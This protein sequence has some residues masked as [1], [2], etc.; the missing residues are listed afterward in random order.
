M[1]RALTAVSLALV[2]AL[3]G[4]GLWWSLRREP[5]GTILDDDQSA[6]KVA[7]A[8]PGQLISFQDAQIPL[9]SF[10]WLPPLPGGFLAAQVLSQ[11]DR[12]R[13]ALFQG[14]APR[15]LLLVQKPVGVADGF[16]RFAQLKDAAQAPGGL[17]VLLY[18]A[19]DSA[20]AEPAL[21]LAL[22]E[23]SQRVHWF[24]RGPCARVAVSPGQQPAVFLFG[25]KASIQRLDLNATG[26]AGR[27]AAKSIELPPEMAEVEDLL[28]TGAWSFLVSHRNGL[29][30]WQNKSGWTLCPAPEDRGVDCQDWK[31][32]LT[33]SG[34]D[35]WWQAVPG[36]LVKV[37]ADGSSLD[38]WQADLGTDPF[39]RDARLLRLL[40]TDPG[41]AL[42][43]TLAS[44]KPAPPAPA[45]AQ[46][47]LPPAPEAPFE[48]SGQEAAVAPQDPG[49]DWAAY[50]AQ[51]LDRVYRWQPGHHTLERVSLSKE[52][53]AALHPPEAVQQPA[54]GQGLVPA[55]GA[56]LAEG[57]RCCWWLPLAALPLE[58]LRQAM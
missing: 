25:G 26:T 41:G 37:R 19:G 3:L 45:P 50:L 44:P 22:D 43:F 49:P 29:A 10:R 2:A 51:G 5:A 23:A 20:S 38:T 39:A 24:Y 58:K 46:A 21:V 36:R 17:W 31:S 55:S 47:G 4:T 33:R 32:A 6:F 57:T 40:G 11:N 14:G 52:A 35:L 27:A 56:L 16:W 34:K 18:Q 9:R 28:P 48:A 1:K 53:W 13:V 7:A 42:W 15:G 12:Q 8:G 30:A 54:A